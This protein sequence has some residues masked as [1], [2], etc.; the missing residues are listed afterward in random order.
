MAE[1]E[2]LQFRQESKRYLPGS[3]PYRQ[4]VS[5]SEYRIFP[6]I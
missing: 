4:K 2:I 1:R 5:L 3:M 6:L